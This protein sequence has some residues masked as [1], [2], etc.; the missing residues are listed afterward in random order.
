ME[1]SH[2]PDAAPSSRWVALWQYSAFAAVLFGIKLWL[3]GSY[4]NATP[5]WDQWD[6]EAAGLYKPF[7]EGTLGWTHFFAPH[8]EHRI[9]TTRLLALVL[10]GV[11]GIWNP[12][13]Q[14]VI[15]AGLHITALVFGIVLLTRALGRNHVPVLLVFSTI[16]FSVPY[17]WENTLAG[18]QAQFYFVMLFSI[19]CLWLTV[20]Q[21]PLSAS[22][23]GGVACAILAFLSLASGI[24]APAAAAV[25]GLVLYVS[26]LR[27]TSKQLIA[28]AVLAGLFMLGVGLTPSLAYHASLKAASIPQ[29]M[30][31]LTAVLSWPVAS[32]SLS[33]LIRNVPG[34]AL[35]GC[36]LWS[37][38]PAHDRRWF[39]LALVA[40]TVGQAVSIAYGR[41]VG[42]RSSRYLDLFAVAVLVNLACLLALVQDHIGK[43][44]SWILAGGTLWTGIMLIALGVHV[45]T[46]LPA[47]LAMK[48]DIGLAQEL[49]TKHYLQTGDFDHLQNKTHLHVPYPHPQRLASILDEPTVRAI[50]PFNIRR[51]L[52]TISVESMPVG[53]FVT[54]GIPPSTPFRPGGVVGSYSQSGD[55]TTGQAAIT[56]EAGGHSSAIGIPVAGYP[57]SVGMQL[58][59]DQK[60]QRTS[61]VIDRN[62]KETWHMVYASVRSRAFTIHLTDADSTSWLA[63]GAPIEMGRL[64]WFTSALLSIS[65]VIAAMGCVALVF[66]TTTRGRINGAMQSLWIALM[67][68]GAA[69]R[70]NRIVVLVYFGLFGVL[71]VLIGA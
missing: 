30:H 35:A 60:G 10:L 18:F 27:R 63:V 67:T 16:L 50:L 32:N 57:R 42:N 64:D 38:P 9:F 3:I 20:T 29:F 19:V 26:G 71:L 39:L 48:R 62:P 25:V 24:F 41:A 49:H 23:W 51:P 70:K 66:L 54:P 36:M 7:F 59:I 69:Y 40:W 43:R 11:N 46:R 6:A 28:V 5:Y 44:R 52:E 4:G 45:G 56:Y 37:R 2:S 15:N 22:W 14:M 1:G 8:N 21:P 55:A 58:E 65:P 12:L 53:A 68:A 17:G 13:L 31:A 33:A 34:L 61:V 47:A